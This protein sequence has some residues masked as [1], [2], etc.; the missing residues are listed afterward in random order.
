MYNY[1]NI[2]NTNMAKIKSTTYYDED[3]GVL[4]LI[5]EQILYSDRVYITLYFNDY[6]D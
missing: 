6:Y 2:T 5:R 1:L 3:I 4:G